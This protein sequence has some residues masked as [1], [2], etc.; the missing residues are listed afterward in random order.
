MLSECFQR[1]SVIEIELNLLILGFVFCRLWFA[2]PKARKLRRKLTNKALLTEKIATEH[3]TY[4]TTKMLLAISVLC[5]ATQI[6][7]A[8]LDISN[9]VLFNMHYYEECAS[10]WSD[11]YIGLSSVN[12]MGTFFVYYLISCKFRGTLKSLV[13]FRCFGIALI[14]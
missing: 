12:S 9:T 5:L 10:R 4:R 3:S 7:T 13:K 6:P 2:L 8:I 11:W 1:V 14:K